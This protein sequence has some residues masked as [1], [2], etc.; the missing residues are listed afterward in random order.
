LA[1]AQP[2]G[3]EIGVPET[4]RFQASAHGHEL[5][6]LVIHGQDQHPTLGPRV[7][8]CSAKAFNMMPKGVLLGEFVADAWR[9]LLRDGFR[10]GHDRLGLITGQ[11]GEGNLRALTQ[12]VMAAGTDSDRGLATRIR[13]P[14]AF[15]ATH[16]ALW[17][18]ARCPA[19]MADQ[20]GIDRE[21]SP[22]RLLR[23][24]IPRRFDLERADSVD[25]AQ[26]CSWCRTALVPAQAGSAADLLKAVLTRVEKARTTGGSVDFAALAALRPDL[27]FQVRPDAEAAW[28]PVAEHTRRAADGLRDTLGTDLRVP[29]RQAWDTLQETSDCPVV[30]LTGPSGCGK[31]ALAKRWMTAEQD[32]R[33]VWLSALD[34]EGGLGGLRARLGLP[35]SFVWLLEHLPGST[36]VVLDGLDRAFAPAALQAAAELAGIAQSSAGRIELL[37]PCQPMALA[38]VMRALVAAGVRAGSP[39]TIGD[40]DDADL[41]ILY[42]RQPF[43]RLVADGDLREV[44]RRPKLL[45]LV[46][47]ASELGVA[48]LGELRDETDVAGL[49]W[50][51][52]ALAGEDRPARSALLQ[53]LAARQAD[54][55]RAATPIVEV[56]AAAVG[57]VHGLQ[58]DGVLASGDEQLAFA[59]DLFGDWARLK[60]LQAENDNVTAFLVGKELLP[61]WH[62]AVRLL[63]LD[64]LRRDPAEWD[65]LRVTMDTDGHRLLGDLFLDAVVFADDA[66][67]LLDDNWARLID[68]DGAL[69]RRLLTRFLAVAT[70]PDPR[71]VLI[72]PN[73]PVLQA[74]FAARSRVPVWP[75][76]PAVLTVL[77]ARA[78][79][80]I[81]LASEMVARIAALWL[82]FSAEGWPARPAAAE[83]GLAIGRFVIEQRSGGAYFDE[84]LELVLY[85]A[86]LAAGAVKS[87][88]TVDLLGAALCVPQGELD[89]NSGDWE[90]GLPHSV[91]RAVK[92]ASATDTSGAATISGE[93]SDTLDR[94]SEGDPAQSTQADL[95]DDQSQASGERHASGREEHER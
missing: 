12:L 83:L 46:L 13:T 64:V 34:L 49:W 32:T 73:E 38:R 76:W 59:H 52:I 82:H 81:E 67:R 54:S 20:Y 48:E 51:H 57:P 14:G 11:A 23:H 58:A 15:N 5:D 45:D 74:H 63:A 70:V 90:F 17:N 79:Q 24:L 43:L 29:R 26:A 61:P 28:Q 55:L 95:Q 89:E 92:A 3:D 85:R 25:A 78:D 22:A 77:A 33:A 18:S 62:R 42:E 35:V 37:V 93:S 21:S 1:G 16:R 94:E 41:A 65:R 8:A 66:L 19:D 50:T 56:G 69:L 72:F 75:L 40:L 30:V 27:L 84:D 2:F 44:L 86:A 87:Q 88:Q 47:Q 9:E 60:R 31:S 4:V 7:M 71:G 10:E 68:E 6:D 39:V 80:A 53:E 36:R 91:L